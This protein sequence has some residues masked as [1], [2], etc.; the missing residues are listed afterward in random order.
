MPC[1]I[2]AVDSGL[3]PSLNLQF[4]VLLEKQFGSNVLGIGYVGMRGHDLMMAIPDINRAVPSGTATPNP[5]PYAASAPRLTTIGYYTTQGVSQ[6][7]ALQVTFNRRLSKGLSF[8]TGFTYA[9]S[10]DDITGLGTSTG[11]YGNLSGGLASVVKNIRQYDWATSD[12]NIKYRF[13]FGGNYQ[14]PFFQS[15][16][17][18]A[19][20]VLGG[21]QLNGSLIWQTGLPFTVTDSTSTS[22][23]IGLSTERPNLTGASLFTPSKTVGSTGQYLNPAAFALPA[24]SASGSTALGTEPRNVDYGPRQSV[25]NMSLFKTFR[26]TERFNLQFR[27]EVFNLPNHP[28]FGNPN[29]T[30]GNANFGTITQLAG[31]YNPRQ[32]QFALKLLF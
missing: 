10:Q 13:S 4:N 16:K 8:T 9:D 23:V 2:T 30:F 31:P 22:G 17:G 3:K 28:V 1:S 32:I 14:L 5:R 6:Y 29:T 20:Q 26:L 27:T 19:G 21:W 12:F 15:A 24:S 7:N 18:F 25:V 11:G